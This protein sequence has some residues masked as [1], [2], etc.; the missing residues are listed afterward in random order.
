MND[1]AATAWRPDRL[2]RALLIWTALTTVFFWLPTVR[3]PFDGPSYQWG[4]FGF[5]GRGTDG[6]YWFPVLS[7]CIALFTLALGWRGTRPPFHLLLVAWHLF[8]ASAVTYYSVTNPSAVRFQGD[9]LGVDVSLAAVGPLLFGVWACLAMY[10]AISD[11]RSPKSAAEPF[12]GPWNTRRIG[13][14]VALFPIQLVLLRFAQFPAADPIG[15]VL[16]I[17]QWMLLGP[18]L[19]AYAI[20]R[21]DTR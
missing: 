1:A 13:I 3:G 19:R 12:S 5:G 4:L 20:P 7:A 6:D 2:L 17:L 9:T 14:L 21:D 15:V 16:T 8:L 18:S 11:L 10:W